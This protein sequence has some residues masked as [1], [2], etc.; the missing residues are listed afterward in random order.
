MGRKLKH[1]NFEIY[2]NLVLLYF[3]T[4]AALLYFIEQ[5]E[6]KDVV[7]VL[8]MMDDFRNNEIKLKYNRT[9]LLIS[10]SR[11]TVESRIHFPLYCF[12]LRCSVPESNPPSTLF[13]LL[14]GS[15]LCCL[16]SSPG[17]SKSS[18]PLGKKGF[19]FSLF[20]LEKIQRVALVFCPR[21]EGSSPSGLGQIKNRT[22]CILENEVF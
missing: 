22:F 4:D 9:A 15:G 19:A 6:F 18:N 3:Y 5:P 14:R 21:P 11:A 16:L 13:Y 17:C 20:P 8:V 2:A 1:P 7:E 12:P 10:R